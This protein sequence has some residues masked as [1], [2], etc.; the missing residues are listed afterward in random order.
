MHSKTRVNTIPMLDIC[1]VNPFNPNGSF[2]YKIVYYFGGCTID[3]IREV[4]TVL[5]ELQEKNIIITCFIGDNLRAQISA[6]KK[7]KMKV[8]KRYQKILIYNQS[9]G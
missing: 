2:L 7:R 1:L 6:L 5:E 4:K 8:F 9:I 3:Y